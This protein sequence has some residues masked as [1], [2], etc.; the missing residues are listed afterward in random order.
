[1]KDENSRSEKDYLG[2]FIIDISEIIQKSNFHPAT[3][4]AMIFIQFMQL[5]IIMIDIPSFNLSAKFETIFKYFDVI[6]PY[7]MINSYNLTNFLIILFTNLSIQIII[8]AGFFFIRRIKKTLSIVK[9][10]CLLLYLFQYN[11]ILPLVG[12]LMAVYR[13]PNTFSP[14]I[15]IAIKIA[16]TFLAVVN[17]FIEFVISIFVCNFFLHSKDAF[18]RTP[19]LT[20]AWQQFGLIF[21]LMIDIFAGKDT[22]AWLGSMSNVLFGLYFFFDFFIRLPYSNYIVTMAN[23]YSIFVYFW[24]TIMHL[25]GTHLGIELVQRNAFVFILV[26]AFLLLIDLYFL[27]DF[28]QN[29][30]LNTNIEDLKNE[31]YIGKK[32]LL[33]SQLMKGSKKSKAD[34]LRLASLIHY[35]ITGCKNQSCLCKN[36]HLVFNSFKNISANNDLPVFKDFVLIKSIFFSIMYEMKNQFHRSNS[37]TIIYILFLLEETNNFAMCGTEC[38][39]YE[40][41][42]SKTNKLIDK[43]CLTRIKAALMNNCKIQNLNGGPNS[44]SYEKLVLYDHHLDILKLSKKQ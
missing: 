1:M 27:R 33:N 16:F 39:L 42:V 8:I 21:L 2:I 41:F 12:C 40:K 10:Y 34:E 11:L 36:R 31:H 6:V 38:F 18:A 30:L 23:F 13:T 28:L 24:I 15:E 37:L 3:A 35:H 7:K 9:L 14:S 32:I 26:G 17:L 4:S 44:Q 22:N 19:S 25:M 5:S 43:I 29:R 20:F